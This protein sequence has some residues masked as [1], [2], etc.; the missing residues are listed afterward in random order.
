MSKRQESK[1][2]R[3]GFLGGTLAGALSAVSFPYVVS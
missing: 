1:I 3:R 2:N